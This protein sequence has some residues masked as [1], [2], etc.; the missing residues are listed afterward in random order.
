[1]FREAVQA[2]RAGQRRRARDLLTRLIKTDANNADYWVWLSSAVDTEK[3]QVYCLQ[4][5]LEIDPNSIHARRG[6][7]ML[8]ALAPEQANLP[9]AA[10]IDELATNAPARQAATRFQRAWASRRIQGLA[11]VGL[12]VVLAGVV[13]YWLIVNVVPGLFPRGSAA[14]ITTTPQPTPTET[15]TPTLT[16]EATETSVG[17]IAGCQPEGDII[18]AKPLSQYLC[19][20]PQTPT[21]PVPTE[22]SARPEEAY[23]NVRF[24]YLE[25][26][27]DRVIQNADQAI[28]LYPDSP[29]PYFYLAEAYRAG[30]TGESL[31]QAEKN[32]TTA[33]QK[34]P[35]FTAAYW[36]RALVRF[37]LSGSN[38]R[39]AL[40]DL[41][42]AI[43]A[44]PPFLP[45]L[46]VRAD[47]YLINGET[48]RAVEDLK[49]AQRLSPNDPHVLGQLANTYATAGDV[50]RAIEFADAALKLNPAE[51]LAL[52]GRGRARIEL[53]DLNGAQEDL[54]LS[55]PYVLDARAFAELFPA[56][57]AMSIR[58]RPQADA[59]LAQS[60][61][62]RRRGNAAGALAY[63]NQ[64]LELR[65][66]FPAG[67]VER[68]ELLL[69]GGELEAA[70]EDFNRAIGMLG[71]EPD[72]D[73]T[74]IR[75]YIGNGQALLQAELPNGALSNFQ[76][77]ARGAPES[78]D[79]NL[80]LGLASL[81]I[82]QNVD[83]VKA[84]SRA[85]SVAETARQ[86]ADVLIA[87][88]AA[89]RALKRYGEE[90][91]DLQTAQS[92][93]SAMQQPTI[94]ARL[95][96]VHDLIT[97]TATPTTPAPTV[98][99]TATR[100]S[101]KNT[102]TA[103]AT[104]TRT[105]RRTATPSPSRTPAVTPTQRNTAPPATR[106]PTP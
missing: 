1:M 104:T 78:Y 89:F 17:L 41:E 48:E 84:L 68:G 36:G 101:P 32:Y 91:A 55:V 40:D 20:P 34:S 49:A 15:T 80:G 43:G 51:V 4:K 33:L 7:V 102:A 92:I 57:D 63:I 67:L 19:L 62:E 47:F 6:L 24:G 64:A 75:A 35:G 23:Q 30:G 8:G 106:T 44:S 105:P 56:A 99:G 93:A 9:P 85:L 73:P 21:S 60:I 59:L 25:K 71:G 103:A 28:T 54:R 76:A 66:A 26:N 38:T 37:T 86:Q 96:E 82:D 14:A 79:V 100:T 94:V 22:Q 12:A 69:S 88:A 10:T 52:F 45:A 58:S 5:A 61:V 39:R 50:D 95:T 31:V 81:G 74:L 90:T 3:E 97:P 11:G 53:D 98:T 16:P 42:Q 18:A 2:V 13:G 65:A 29:Y 27:W 87:R 72:T 70:R 83:A 77:A 46:L